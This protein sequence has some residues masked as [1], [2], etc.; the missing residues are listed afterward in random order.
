[1]WVMKPVLG[2]LLSEM[3]QLSKLSIQR[4]VHFSDVT[5]DK[6]GYLKAIP[7]TR[8]SQFFTKE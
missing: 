6:D 5:V 2:A 3:H 8:R 4:G 7:N 1:M